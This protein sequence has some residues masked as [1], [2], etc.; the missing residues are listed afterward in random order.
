MELRDLKMECEGGRVRAGNDNKSI[1]N[2]A[3][4]AVLSSLKE[5]V[6]L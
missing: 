3:S 6:I 1:D 2:L 5:I 4:F